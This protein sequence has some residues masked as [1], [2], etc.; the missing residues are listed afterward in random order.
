MKKGTKDITFSKCLLTRVKLLCGNSTNIFHIS[1]A[2]FE[3]RPFYS[4]TCMFISVTW[5]L[6]SS[7]AG[8]DLIMIK[9]SLFLLCKSSLYYAN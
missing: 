9:N 7:E 5:P 1:L 4:C 6:N 2:K 8:G 3:N